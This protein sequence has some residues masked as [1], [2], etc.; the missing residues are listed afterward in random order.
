[1]SAQKTGWM[2]YI[3]FKDSGSKLLSTKSFKKLNIVEL[4]VLMRKVIK[5]ENKVNELMRSFIEERIKDISV[6]AFQDP[7]MVKYYKPST[8]HNMTLTDECL[9]K[10]HLKFIKYVEGQ[11]RCKSNR[12]D[13]NLAATEVLYAFRL[14]RAIKVSVSTLKKES[15]LYLKSVY[16]LKEDGTKELEQIS[17]SMP[18]I[19]IRNRKAWFRLQRSR[20]GWAKVT[21]DSLKENN[22]NSIS[23]VLSLIKWSTCKED[24]LY[25]EVVDK[26]L[27]EKLLKKK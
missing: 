19:K 22:S 1:M 17:D 18:C 26:I 5:G 20:G 27:R 25:V 14:Y 8:L 24:K 3:N 23:R 9:D 7:P 10:S 13:Q 11:L 2:M 6:E 4:F 15:R 16:A 21:I 12:T